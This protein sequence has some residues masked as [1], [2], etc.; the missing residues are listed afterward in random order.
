MLTDEGWVETERED[1]G[2][3]TIN[4]IT[5]ELRS[6]ESDRSVIDQA[7]RLLAA[8]AP[9]DAEA[10]LEDWFEEEGAGV[11]PY[12]AEAYR[13]RGDALLAMGREYKALF[14]YEAVIREFPA[15]DQFLIA[16]ER[17]FDVGARYLGRTRD[18]ESIP[19]LNRRFWGGPRWTD[20][21]TT[22]EELLIRVQERVPGS[23][24]AELAAI[25][26][27]D[28]Y[29]DKREM[30][31]AAEMYR[32][33]LENYPRSEL[34]RHAMERRVQSNIARY[35]GPRYDG[36][37][38]REA[39]LLIEVFRDRYPAEAERAGITD[40]LAV[41]VREQLAEQMFEAAQTYIARGDEPAGCYTLR[42]LR[43]VFPTTNAAGDAWVLMDGLG[44]PMFVGERAATTT[45]APR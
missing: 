29:F 24:L 4:P 1:L 45:E 31:L 32:I 41:R 17:E 8:Q 39:A 10:L 21:S 15:S 38:L 37:S 26:L 9:E 35:K 40:A 33:F 44:C 42:R 12:L 27:A 36:S 30:R 13:L 28:Y 34:R 22:G 43:E 19:A 2:E 5:G 6:L 16:L 23:R 20:A 14:E 25:T 7:R 11:S 18:R 3:D